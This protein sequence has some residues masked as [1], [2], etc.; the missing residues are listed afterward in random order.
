MLVRIELC[1]TELKMDSPVP[2]ENYL[3]NIIIIISFIFTAIFCIIFLFLILYLF[4][5]C[6]A[7]SA[8]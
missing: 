5:A 6:G 1:C 3:G 7:I 2:A 8:I 4:T